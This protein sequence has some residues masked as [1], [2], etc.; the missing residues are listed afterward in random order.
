[1]RHRYGQSRMHPRKHLLAV[2]VAALLIPATAALAV[3]DPA[4]PEPR[5]INL[6]PQPL[7]IGGND[8]DPGE[9]PHQVGLIAAGFEGNIWGGQFCG[10]ALIDPLWVMTAAHCVDGK[11]PSSLFIYADSYDL[12]GGGTSITVTAIFMHEQYNSNTVENDIALIQ[13]NS[14]ASSEPIRYATPDEAA[15]FADGTNAIVTGWG[16]TDPTDQNSYPSILQEAVVP[17]VSDA[18][19]TASYGVWYVSPEMLCAG[20]DEGGI[21]SCFGDSGGP[22]A[23][24]AGDGSLLHIGIVSWGV[25][26]AQAG[27]PGVYARTSTYASWIFDK[28]GIAGGVK[29]DP[30]MLRVVSDPAVA[31]QILVDTIIRDTWGLTWL[32]LP[33]GSYAVSFSD[34]EGFSTPAAQ[35][36][37]IT[38]ETTT[39]V[40]GSFTQRGFLR[41]FT[42]PAVPGTINVDG[43]PRNDWGMWTDLEPGDYQVCF[44]DVADYTTPACET[45]TITAGNTTNITGTYVADPGASGPTGFGW[46]R[47]TTDPPS[48]SQILVD[49]IPRNSWGL[50]WV[51]LAPGTYEVAFTDVPGL[52]TPTPQ[53]VT[54]T[55]GITTEV[56][57]SFIQRGFLRAITSPAVVATIF[58][59]GIP[60]NDWGMW[61][62]LEPGDYQLC[63]GDVTGYTT[64]TCQTATIT[65][66]DTT[67]LTGTYN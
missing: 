38:E 47:A 11:T 16:D 8:A 30:G 39:T 9:Y 12:G 29:P 2:L 59:D 10:G 65:A 45:A 14:P 48:P 37:T 44:G 35:T 58:V 3:D 19:C 66:G 49:G 43:V 60:R 62:D 4:A 27:Y 40:T 50:D 64:P 21:D 26:C 1:M 32:K 63:F 18:G 54:I 31:S 53:T 33:P 41:V 20:Y 67:I 52:T 6:E 22:L 23:V 15:L 56:T 13:L 55:E 61:T 51:K 25:A 34:L 36:I 17:V 57:G 7:I 28:T 24:D 42:D 46:L 5:I